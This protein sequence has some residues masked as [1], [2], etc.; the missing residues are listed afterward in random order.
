MRAI[1]HLSCSY[2][3]WFGD[4]AYLGSRRDALLFIGRIE[5]F[6]ADFAEL[7]K[8]LHLPGDVDLPTDARLAHRAR[9]GEKPTLEDEAIRRLKAWYRSDYEFIAFCDAWRE[10]QGGPVARNFA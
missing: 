3:D 9:V 7:K 8:A 10:E 1:T 2:W 6:D 5:S 4:V